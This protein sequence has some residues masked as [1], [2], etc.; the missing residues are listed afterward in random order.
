MESTEHQ[1]NS[2]LEIRSSFMGVPFSSDASESRAAVLGVPF[3]CGI[4]PTRIGAR[5]GPAAIREQSALVR[6]Y[7]P[8][9]WDFDPL[10]RLNVVDCGDVA[11][12]PGVITPS[13]DS[14]EQAVATVVSAGA[15]PV[16]MG[17]DGLVTLPQLRALHR[18]YSDLVV[19]HID[20]HTD[21]YPGDGEYEHQRYNTATT[22]SRAAEEGLIDTRQS[23]HIGAR[24]TVTVP[25][26][27][28]HTRE[29]GYRLID[30][31]A[32]YARGFG[33]V[34][35]EVHKILADKPVYLCFDMDFFDP[36]CAPGVCTPTFGGATAQQGLQLITGLQGL[37]LVAVD[38]NTVSPPHDIGGMTAFLAATVMVQ[39]LA[40][41][42]DLSTGR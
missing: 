23:F 16:T 10:K 11:C 4:H 18:R 25:G 8:P 40:L 13:L 2:G 37:N 7:Q 31:A 15:V 28:E 27:F 19:L 42:C 20:A 32:L 26:V 1:Q 36:S 17:G 5:L 33:S 6:P 24:G 35:S 29:M 38:V 22:F 30:G 3:D 12:T 34:L 14:I 9:Q 21:T 39:C 41:L